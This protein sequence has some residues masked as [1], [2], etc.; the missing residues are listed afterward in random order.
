MGNVIHLWEFKISNL[1][2]EIMQCFPDFLKSYKL[3]FKY[4]LISNIYKYL[5]TVGLF[6]MNQNQSKY[7]RGIYHLIINSLNCLQF[8]DNFWV[9]WKLGYKSG[10]RR[11]TDVDRDGI[12]RGYVKEPPWRFLNF[13]SCVDFW[14]ANTAT[15]FLTLKM[16]SV[17]FTLGGSTNTTL[18]IQIEIW[19]PS[20]EITAHASALK[21]LVSS[22]EAV[23]ERRNLSVSTTTTTM[24][25]EGEIGDEREG[26]RHLP[27]R[28]RRNLCHL[29]EDGSQGNVLVVYVT[30][31]ESRDEGAY[32]LTQP[33][34]VAHP[35][36]QFSH[37]KQTTSTLPKITQLDGVQPNSS[38]GITTTNFNF[39]QFKTKNIYSTLNS[40]L[41]TH[42]N[43]WHTACNP[44]QSKIHMGKIEI[45]FQLGIQTLTAD[46]QSVAC[47]TYCHRPEESDS[48]ILN[49]K[50]SKDSIPYAFFDIFRPPRRIKFLTNFLSGWASYL[51]HMNPSSNRFSCKGINQRKFKDERRDPGS[52][53]VIVFLILYHDSTQKPICTF[54]PALPFHSPNKTAHSNTKSITLSI[55]QCFLN[56]SE[57]FQH[58][59]HSISISS[60]FYILLFQKMIFKLYMSWFPDE[61]IGKC[62]VQV[63]F[64]H[65]IKLCIEIQ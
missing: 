64:F 47:D 52:I 46:F 38:D 30:A 28:E 25:S 23:R 5:Y 1:T 4:V 7:Y 10:Y 48:S 14:I 49:L 20:L 35:V 13:F 42:Q 56:L 62:L 26:G 15:T 58:E 37:T 39:G 51:F 61:S 21:Q 55:Q 53:L 17:R 44:K 65:F 50:L 57:I 19:I 6:I 3:N 32:R 8:W 2:I 29:G 60:F 31:C 9:I 34:S 33:V 36:V 40:F 12:S 63:Y 22:R 54:L 24:D 18:Y 43:I 27:R 41:I 59:N 45:K 11:D 16:V